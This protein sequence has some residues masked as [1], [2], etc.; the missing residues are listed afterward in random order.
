MLA[1]PGPRPNSSDPEFTDLYHQ[2]LHELVGIIETKHS[3]NP[4]RDA[5]AILSKVIGH[6]IGNQ[7]P[8]TDEQR[9]NLLRANL[10]ISAARGLGLTAQEITSMLQPIVK[11]GRIENFSVDALRTSLEDLLI[12][13]PDS[14]RPHLLSEW[15]S[16]IFYLGSSIRGG[17][18]LLILFAAQMRGFDHLKQPSPQDLEDVLLGMSRWRTK[19]CYEDAAADFKSC[20]SYA[21]LSDPDSFGPKERAQLYLK[22]RPLLTV[23]DDPALVR[24]ICATLA[25][26]FFSNSS[27]LQ[28]LLSPPYA[29]QDARLLL[30]TWA[31]RFEH[32][33]REHFEPALLP[34]LSEPNALLAAGKALK[35]AKQDMAIAC[36]AA[37]RQGTN[38]ES[39]QLREAKIAHRIALELAGC[40]LSAR[41]DWA[42]PLLKSATFAQVASDAPDRIPELVKSLTKLSPRQLSQLL[43]HSDE[44]LYRDVLHNSSAHLLLAIL[45]HV[46]ANGNELPVMLGAIRGY[47]VETCRIQPTHDHSGT[48]KMGLYTLSPSRP[49]RITVNQEFLFAWKFDPRFVETI[50]KSWQTWSGGPH[51]S[52]TSE[53]SSIDA[54]HARAEMSLYITRYLDE[55]RGFYQTYRALQ[56]KPPPHASFAFDDSPFTRRPARDQAHHETFRVMSRNFDLSLRFFTFLECESKRVTKHQGS[57]LERFLRQSF[58][59]C[60]PITAPQSGNFPG[61]GWLAHGLRLSDFGLSPKTLED[62]FPAQPDLLTHLDDLRILMTRGLVAVWCP[63]CPATHIDGVPQAWVFYNRHF[64]PSGNCVGSLVDAVHL[65]EVVSLLKQGLPLHDAGDFTR[66]L[67]PSSKNLTWMGNLSGSLSNSYQFDQGP[68]RGESLQE[69]LRVVR[70][71]GGHIHKHYLVH[72]ALQNGA[73]SMADA[74]AR[75]QDAHTAVYR[76]FESLHTLFNSGCLYPFSLFKK[77][78]SINSL[79]PADIARLQRLDAIDNPAL[80]PHSLLMLLYAEDVQSGVK[81]GEISP[82]KASVIIYE[83]PLML[84]RDNPK[85]ALDCATLAVGTWGETG[86]REIANL[87]EFEWPARAEAFTRYFHKA[88]TSNSIDLKSIPRSWIGL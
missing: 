22:I 82:E 80:N 69:G 33:R 40:E 34:A 11:L 79:R 18:A 74:L 14:I 54:R 25:S 62:R 48:Y 32:D 85:I 28:L 56:G 46:A 4:E 42:E 53:K 2:T 66:L 7:I 77:G 78:F 15:P 6:D 60:T 64:R 19:T 84:R 71:P 13:Q 70:E 44:A 73:P 57:L 83:D 87:S 63:S 35:T 37:V 27:G 55:H 61:N 67:A 8:A 45:P 88:L 65:E 24:R 76:A 81:S 50:T 58:L 10:C 30:L 5:A 17:E 52:K 59:T 75:F 16:A 21:P 39:P 36:C 49:I 68:F 23:D 41:A 3:I 47:Q 72:S 1:L 12:G 29:E 9:C 86:W 43:A 26:P 38:V 51:P 31:S 20:W